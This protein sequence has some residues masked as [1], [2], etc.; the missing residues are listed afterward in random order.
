MPKD[1]KTVSQY[2]PKVIPRKNMQNMLKNEFYT[3]LSPLSPKKEGE[4]VDYLK[5][6]K[7]TNVLWINNKNVNLSKKA[8]ISIDTEVVKIHIKMSIQL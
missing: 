3:K 1:I 6:L 5:I 8:G 7:R 2:Y 4:K